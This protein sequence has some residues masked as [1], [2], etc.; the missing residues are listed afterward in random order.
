MVKA[1]DTTPISKIPPASSTPRWLYLLWWWVMI[2]PVVQLIFLT[3]LIWTRTTLVPYMD[4]WS[5]VQFIKQARANHL[6]LGDFWALHNEH[7]IVV[8][9]LI[10]LIVINL[11][12]WNRSSFMM[13]NLCIA[14]LCL[15]LLL[16][17][18]RNTLNSRLLTLALV[19]P[20]SLIFLSLSAFDNW[21]FPFQIAFIATA[22]GAIVTTWA[23]SLATKTW[24]FVLAIL[25]AVWGTLSSLGG[26]TI[27]LAFLPTIY[28]LGGIRRS[29]L[30]MMTGTTIVLIYFID[31]PKRST[32]SITVLDLIQYCL[33]YLGAPIA[34]PNATLSPFIG[35]EMLI[36]GTL[37][38]VLYFQ[39]GGST[40]IIGSWIGLALF[41]MGCAS[42]T[43]LGR[44]AS[45]ATQ[46]LESRYQ[47]F[48][49][50]WLIAIIAICCLA[51]RQYIIIQP[52][53]YRAIMTHLQHLT[54][55]IV[56]IV[57]G[58]IVLPA[59]SHGYKIALI[60]QS[61]LINNQECIRN[62]IS[63]SEGCL[64]L[65]NPSSAAVRNLSAYL[66]EAQ[67]NIFHNPGTQTTVH[68]LR[69]LT[70]APTYS[71]ESIGNIAT[72]QAKTNPPV[73]SYGKPVSV[74][75]W[76]VDSQANTTASAV[77]VRIDQGASFVATYGLDRPDIALQ[78]GNLTY[79][80]S[81]FQ[82]TIPAGWLAPGKHTISLRIISRD[83]T[84]YYEPSETVEITT[85]PF[86]LIADIPVLAQ[87]P[88]GPLS[89]GIEFG[90]SFISSC[91]NLSRIDLLLGTGGG[92]N[93]EPV[94]F[95]VKDV[96]TNTAITE[97]TVPAGQIV[98]NQWQSIFLGP[99]SS[100]QGQE[101]KITLLAPDTQPSNAITVWRSN[102]DIY[103]SGKAYINNQPIEG[104]MIFRY[105]CSP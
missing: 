105:G 96:R 1:S 97:L 49:G 43:A 2:V 103:P 4:E 41:G 38:L 24:W 7:R 58:C 89:Q 47:I 52:I 32:V 42:M 80:K 75:G 30:W 5:F 77:Y 11:S 19:I 59:N 17:I 15:V 25:G 82:V 16:V 29:F 37:A 70:D 79:L 98:N 22:L 71:I 53:Q 13:V 104:D 83:R 102:S 76:A 91:P 69:Q 81:G 56:A 99:L 57:I 27:W 36:L 101:F 90:Q 100:S 26:L 48:S 14:L 64:L 34:Y 18:A 21:M 74:S 31:Y 78:L 45:G 72:A 60:A 9:R 12:S 65:Y 46:A 35:A 6:A 10:S 63:A 62:Y 86:I 66:D 93:K 20:Y 54:P 88:M 84:S 68:Q 94:T 39:S 73:I 92:S 40:Q 8:P 44:G 28:W 50:L 85:G 3:K 55:F 61:E 23:T 51:I 33:A 67:L 87:A 95:R